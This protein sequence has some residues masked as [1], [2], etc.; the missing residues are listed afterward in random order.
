MADSLRSVKKAARVLRA[1]TLRAKE[2][3]KKKKR[4]NSIVHTE[5]FDNLCKS[6]LTHWKICER[7]WTTLTRC[8]HFWLCGSHHPRLS[9]DV[10]IPQKVQATLWL[11]PSL[12][13]RLNAATLKPNQTEKVLNINN[14]ELPL[15]RDHQKREGRQMDVVSD[16][17]R[18][19]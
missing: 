11:Q 10:S 6:C 17:L 13:E 7:W 14:H 16:Y 1:D 2:G 19:A 12:K 15:V 5:Y 4:N 18:P 3:E 9:G 8:I